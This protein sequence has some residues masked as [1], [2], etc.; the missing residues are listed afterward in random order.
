M[1]PALG[2]GIRFAE[3]EPLQHQ[4]LKQLVSSL[5]AQGASSVVRPRV[6]IPVKDPE[7]VND[8][9]RSADHEAFFAQITTYFQKNH[10]LSREEFYQIAKRARRR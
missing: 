5:V 4:H 7:V 9:L 3:I 10:L 1:Y 8:V 6:A 2:M